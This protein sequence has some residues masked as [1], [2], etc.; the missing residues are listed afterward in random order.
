MSH[1][2][3]AALHGLL[4]DSDHHSRLPRWRWGGGTRPGGS[5]VEVGQK[6]EHVFVC[7]SDHYHLKMLLM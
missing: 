5:R 4:Q 6:E 3:S 1:T 2:R 7:L